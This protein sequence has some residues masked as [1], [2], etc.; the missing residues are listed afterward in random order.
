[1]HIEDIFIQMNI[2]LSLAKRYLNFTVANNLNSQSCSLL[3]CSM[4]LI[5]PL[6]PAR[7]W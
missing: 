2:N 1:M 4:E 6:S 7:I 5:S 3:L